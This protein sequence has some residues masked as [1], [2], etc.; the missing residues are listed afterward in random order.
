MKLQVN[1]RGTWATVAEFAVRD[2]ARVQ[3]AVSRLAKIL[4]EFRPC[5]RIVTGGG[6]SPK[7]YARLDGGDPFHWRVR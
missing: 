3:L 7:V 5:W 4:V 1:A 6:R 2:V